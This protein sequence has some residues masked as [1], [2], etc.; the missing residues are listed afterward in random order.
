MRNKGIHKNCDFLVLKYIQY[1][2]LLLNRQQ[3]ESDV[4]CAI[5]LRLKL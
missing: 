4:V 2:H 3:E 5:L 1:L